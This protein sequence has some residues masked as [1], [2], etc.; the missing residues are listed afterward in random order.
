MKLLRI[1]SIIPVVLVALYFFACKTLVEVEQITS[2]NDTRSSSNEI[3]SYVEE[4]PEYPGGPVALLSFLSENVVYHDRA[5]EMGIQGTVAL[6]FVVT[7]QGTIGDIEILRGVDPLLDQAAV[8]VVKKITG[9]RPGRQQGGVAVPVW[10]QVPIAFRLLNTENTS[11]SNAIVTNIT[12]NE[13]SSSD[14]IF[15]SVEEPPIYPGGEIALLRWIQENVV[16]PD[17]A[18]EMGIQGT[19][20]LQF[21]VTATGGIG[22]VRIL[23]G[24]DPLL[25]QAA[26]NVVKKITGFRP[27]R[28]GGQA[29]S[30][31]YNVQISF[32]I[33][34]SE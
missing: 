16:Y 6:R 25:D 21:A 11:T 19:V 23:R 7:A 30:V 1:M 3:F 27:G 31:W 15:T 26:I 20:T 13:T 28:Q 17:K 34:T 18:T 9:F 24:V 2:V 33:I 14:V 22:D 4:M 5:I 29:V 8:E 12:R 32:R 10:Y